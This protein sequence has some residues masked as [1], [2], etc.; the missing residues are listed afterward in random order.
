MERLSE[1]FKSLEKEVSQI[2]HTLGEVHTAIIGNPL[3]ED[4]GM[5]FRIKKAETLLAH[6]E[7]WI[8]AAEKKQ[9]K[10]NVYTIIMWAA[11]GAVASMIFAYIV[12]LIFTLK[13]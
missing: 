2:K 13:K 6:L 8:L 11:L 1:D 12:N 3:T 9:I 5:V 4:G 10:Y 7:E